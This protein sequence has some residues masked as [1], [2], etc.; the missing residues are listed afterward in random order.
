M[1]ISRY[2]CLFTL[3]SVIGW[4]Y[5]TTYCTIKTGKWENRGFLYGPV[6]P[7][8]GTGAVG[9]ILIVGF[10]DSSGITMLPWQI[11][12]ISVIGSAILEYTTSWSLEKIFHA[13]WWDYKGLPLNIH[14]RISLFTSL[15]FGCA[16]LLIV[17][18]LAPFTGNAI[19]HL[20]PVLAECFAL[21]FVF[22]FAV[23]ITLTVSVLHHFDKMVIQI[24]EKFNQNMATLVDEVTNRT[25]RF[26]QEIAE[27]KNHVE[28]EIV[29]LSE[30]TK[31]TIRR[32]YYFRDNNKKTET[33]KNQILS[34]VKKVVGRSDSSEDNK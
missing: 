13:V 26:K 32:A 25:N 21:I 14:G 18:K 20:A 30:F 22:L 24:D 17:Y 11:F 34:A 7:I 8:Y 33:I 31:K 16:G 12:I 9:I 27:T 10:A 4:I 29:I 1:L 23:D 5:E 28:D 3:Y 2:V 6:C 15:C 19:E